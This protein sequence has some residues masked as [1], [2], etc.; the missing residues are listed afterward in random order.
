MCEGATFNCKKLTPFHICEGINCKKLTPIHIWKTTN[1]KK[2]TPFHIWKTTNYKKLPPFHICETINCKKLTPSRVRET[3]NFESRQV[4]P[5]LS[6]GKTENLFCVTPVPGV[7]TGSFFL[8]SLPR[9]PREWTAYLSNKSI[10][11]RHCRRVSAEWEDPA[12][13]YY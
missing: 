12:G 2:L 8:G 13:I 3:I 1:C 4:L 11:F 5:K 6:T 7:P 10:S 9:A